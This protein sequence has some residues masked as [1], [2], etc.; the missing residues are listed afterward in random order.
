MMQAK[1]QTMNNKTLKIHYIVL[2]CIST[3]LLLTDPLKCQ[4]SF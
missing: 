1:T 2:Q 3:K 4:S